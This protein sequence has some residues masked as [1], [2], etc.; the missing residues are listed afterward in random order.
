MTVKLGLPQCWWNIGCGC[1][2]IG[3]WGGY[4]GWRTMRWQQNWVECKTSS[5]MICTHQTL[6][7]WSNREVRWVGHMTCIGDGRGEY[8]ILVGQ[9]VGKKRLG[10]HRYRWKDNMSV[11]MNLQ[12]VGWGTWLNWSGSGYR[13]VV[14]TCKRSNEPSGSRKFSDFL[15]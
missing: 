14:G 15:D 4:L 13:Q 5:F 12:D 3:C 6:F 9:P 11:K 2:R 10:R 7:W 8:R 1:L